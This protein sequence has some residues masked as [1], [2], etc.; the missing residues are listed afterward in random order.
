MSR[1]TLM[2]ADACGLKST[3][4]IATLFGIVDHQPVVRARI[5]LT[6]NAGG[7]WQALPQTTIPPETFTLI[8]ADADL[9]VVQIAGLVARRI[10]C[11]LA[12]GERVQRG[13]RFGMIRFGSRLDVYL[14]PGA[15]VVAAS[16]MKTVAGETV[17]AELI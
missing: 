14:P 2:V 1:L 3:R 12:Q 16:G 17:L 5:G 4:S 6:P 15:R 8:P 13:A 9:V 10:V 11:E 7:L